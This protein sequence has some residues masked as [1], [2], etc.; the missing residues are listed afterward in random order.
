MLLHV[1]TDRRMGLRGRA[2][3]SRTF[4]DTVSQL[5]E[6]GVA[7]QPGQSTA[8]ATALLPLGPRSKT[9]RARMAGWYVRRPFTSTCEAPCRSQR[10]L[11]HCASIL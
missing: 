1:A 10:S 2:H 8:N 3:L 6:Q 9:V 7:F 5:A 4:A 11:S